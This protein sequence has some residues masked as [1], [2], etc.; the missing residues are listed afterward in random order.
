[1]SARAAALPG[2][3][4]P[5]EMTRRRC[6][7]SDKGWAGRRGA[8]IERRASLCA[9]LTWGDDIMAYKERD[10]LDNYLRLAP[11][12]PKGSPLWYMVQYRDLVKRLGWKPLKAWDYLDMPPQAAFQAIVDAI[13]PKPIYSVARKRAEE[14][15]KPVPEAPDVVMVEKY[16]PRVDLDT[17]MLNASPVFESGE[18]DMMLYWNWV[19]GP[20]RSKTSEQAW[21]DIVR[22]FTAHNAYE[23]IQKKLVPK[24]IYPAARELALQTGWNLPVPKVPA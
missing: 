4:P 24:E 5:I 14:T 12:A 6:Q 19:Y 15:G 22:D 16:E 2:H 21:R 7:P 9:R 13:V 17:Y 23:A 8:V 11:P 20:A 3:E 18:W 10:N 1:V